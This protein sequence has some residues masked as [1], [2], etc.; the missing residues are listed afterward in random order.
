[1][2]IY[3]YTH[4]HTHTQSVYL[5]HDMSLFVYMYVP[6]EAVSRVTLHWDRIHWLL[7]NSYII[8]SE[9]NPSMLHTGEAF[10]ARILHLISSV[11][12]LTSPQHED[13]FGGVEKTQ[14]IEL[15]AVPIIYWAIT[16]CWLLLLLMNAC[17]F[18]MLHVNPLYWYLL[19]IFLFMDEDCYM[20]VHEWLKKKKNIFDE[21]KGHICMRE[22]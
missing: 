1:M 22:H 14:C 21:A 20:F 2:C 3:I 4:T 5:Y 18:Y 19:F 13:L 6:P 8:P 11:T 16:F 9:Y 12:V 15:L 10:A 7:V 17:M